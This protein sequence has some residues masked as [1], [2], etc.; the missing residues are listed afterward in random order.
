MY[1]R[2]SELAN[3]PSGSAVAVVMLGVCLLVIYAV[4]RLTSNR[5]ERAVR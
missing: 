5:W 3:F 1:N 2:F 4:S